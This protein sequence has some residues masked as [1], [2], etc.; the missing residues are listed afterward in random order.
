MGRSLFR[1]RPALMVKFGD[2]DEGPDVFAIPL[3]VHGNFLEP[4]F[5]VAVHGGD[6][7]HGLRERLMAL[8][9]PFEAFVYVHGR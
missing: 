1:A 9:E 6:E 3:E 8:G 5:V 4:L 2:A 7:F